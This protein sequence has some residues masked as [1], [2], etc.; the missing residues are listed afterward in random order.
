MREGVWRG[1][2]VCKDG[3]D[4]CSQMTRG[5]RIS[6][7]DVMQGEAQTTFCFLLCLVS[8]RVHVP[9]SEPTLRPWYPTWLK[10]ET[11]IHKQR[12]AG[13]WKDEAAGTTTERRVRRTA[14]LPTLVN[15]VCRPQTHDAL[16]LRQPAAAAPASSA[17]NTPVCIVPDKRHVLRVDIPRKR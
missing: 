9:L 1:G 13:G 7:F 12:P 14:R 5:R 11:L 2:V 6:C 3:D 8:G 16:V 17:A 10:V 15:K 4:T